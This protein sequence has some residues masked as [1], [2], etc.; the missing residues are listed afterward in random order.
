ML[1]YSALPRPLPACLTKGLEDGEIIRVRSHLPL[2]VPLHPER[3]TWRTFDG[4]GFDQP[5][6][7]QCFYAKARR[8]TLNALAMNGIDLKLVRQ[9]DAGEHPARLH[10][11]GVAAHQLVGEVTERVCMD[12]TLARERLQALRR[13]GL[14]IAIDDFGTGY[15]S[16]AYLTQ[17]PLDLLKI[18]K[19]FVAPIGT[20][21]AT[22]Q[23]IEH[24]ISMAQ[25]LGLRMV[26]EGVE[27]AEQAQ[28]LQA[29][30]VQLAQ[31]WL[32]A[33]PM[34]IAQVEQQLRAQQQKR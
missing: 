11:H 27:T 31:G 8:Q 12:A 26:A 5:V 21:A 23:V 14:P 33:K 13:L 30:G 22:S 4:E 29:R 17:L 6:R 18:D 2:R 20:E 7:R 10:A 15:S 28:W 32:F 16:L 9:A 1:T 19:A 25:S 24:I 3:E 34:T